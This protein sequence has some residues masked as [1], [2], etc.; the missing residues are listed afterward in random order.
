M[1]L[2]TVG[3]LWLASASLGSWQLAATLA[4]AIGLGVA[5]GG[6]LLMPR[7]ASN[8]RRILASPAHRPLHEC[9][10]WPAW[11]MVAG[12]MGLGALL[13]RSSLPRPVLG[14]LYLAVG[15]ALVLGSVASW[16]AWRVAPP[17]PR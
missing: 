8:A 2:A 3:A 9:F 17:T 14:A 13:R 6:W 1:A 12:F 11:L 10:A 5:K 4:I 15:L 16:R 7:A